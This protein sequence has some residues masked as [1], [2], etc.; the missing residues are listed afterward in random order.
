VWYATVGVSPSGHWTD[1]VKAVFAEQVIDKTFIVYVQPQMDSVTASSA[2]EDHSTVVL[3]E[4]LVNKT[5]LF[6]HSVL[7]ETCSDVKRLKIQN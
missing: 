5:F 2:L 3:V 6:V 7:A 4:S 1:E